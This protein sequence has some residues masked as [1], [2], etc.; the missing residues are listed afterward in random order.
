LR[1]ATPSLVHLPGVSWLSL[2]L[3]PVD[4]VQAL[5]MLLLL[6]L[7]LLILLQ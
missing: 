3:S 7:L 2:Q 4:L 1:T 5:S 6:L